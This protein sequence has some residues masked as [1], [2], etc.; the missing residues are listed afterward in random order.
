M[1]SLQRLHN[2]QV[3]K[4]RLDP[5]RRLHEIDQA[6]EFIQST[7]LL[8][9]W[10]LK[11][12]P[13]PSLWYAAAGERP[14]PNEHDDPGH[15][16]WGWKDQLLADPRF[17]YARI[18][19]K[20]TFFVTLDLLPY[21]YALSN[22]FGNYH[23]DHLIL[24]EEGRLTNAARSIYE[25][26]LQ[27]G[28]LNSIDLHRVTHLT[29]K[30][31][32]AEYNRALDELQMDFKVMPVGI[33]DS[34]RWHYSMIY[35]IVARQFPSIVEKAGLIKQPDARDTLLQHYLLTVGAARQNQIAKLFK[36]SKAHLDTALQHL[37]ENGNWQSELV[38]SDSCWKD[39]IA[40]AD[41]VL[42]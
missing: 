41:L 38:D 25:A 31:G 24:Y 13:G 28:P 17:F 11:D 1:L 3:D 9:F 16:T 8:A 22:N 42:Q 12:I 37:I 40:K 23:E 26:L 30:Q 7:G 6:I 20:R 27:E 4:W 33:S 34:G 2:Y 32:D 10:P 5:K 21:L 39:W 15:I 35:D 36:W 29:G 14:V 19:C 18:L